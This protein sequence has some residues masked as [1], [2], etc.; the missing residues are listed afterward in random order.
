MP[1]KETCVM[2]ERTKFIG[3][4]LSGEKIAPLCREFGISRVTGHKII[5]RY[6]HGGIK[7]I[8]NR[9]RSPHKHPNQTPFEVEQLIVRVK[10]EKD[11][12]GAPKIR[13][14]VAN[15]YPSIKLPSTSTIHCILERHG[16]VKKRR[17]RNKFKATASYLSTP[18]S[19]ND[20]WC[21]DFKGQ[22]RMLNKDYTYPLTL[23]DQVSR[24]LLSCESLES[25]SESPCFPVFE[26][27][28]QEYGLPRAIRSDNGIPFASGCSMWNLT[29]LSVWWIR[30]GIKL[31]RIEPGNPQQN[32][33][34]ERMH[35]TLKLE[36]ANPPS[37][38]QLQQQEKFDHF[39]DE[40]NCERPHQAL[41]MKCPNDVYQK[42]PRSYQGLPDITYPGFDKTLLI[43]NCGRICIGRQIK[44]HISKAF[45]NQPIGLKQVDAG[46]WQVDFMSYT[47]GYFDEESRKF[48]PNDDPFSLRLDNAL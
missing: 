8:Y 29:K 31:E 27:A 34:H 25:T 41:N 32:G 13:R 6:E 5:D 38:N 35:R 15:K 3:R 9:S 47:L 43:S 16:F 44:V 37:S 30:L 12:W 1:W 10:K 46:I 40:F 4:H 36:A 7:G 42:S 19:P 39:K 48:A 22:F 33:R 21:T 28:F 24:F 14:L 20:L 18:K 23:T 11:K 45:A 17:K 26:E 2:D